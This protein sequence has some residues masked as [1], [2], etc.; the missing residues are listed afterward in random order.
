I[1]DI[2]GRPGRRT[3]K[4]VIEELIFKYNVDFI[5]A[6]GEN[7]AG[8][9]G[10]TKNVAE[11]LFDYKIDCL[12]MGNHTWDNKEIFDFIEEE[13]RIVR[14]ANYPPETP[15]RG[16][17]ILDKNDIKIGIINLLGRVFLPP[18]NCPFQEV[19]TILKK[20]KDE[21]DIIIVDF[22]A[23]ATSEKMAMGWFLDGKVSAVLG[24]HTHVQT[25]DE[26]ILPRGT[27]YI[28]DVG[29][30]GPVNSVLGVRHELVVNKFITQLPT[31]F[32]VASGDT[33]FNGAIIETNIKDGKANR[34]IR[35]NF[36]IDN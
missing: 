9:A 17:I 27:G 34:I 18:L 20:I 8:G 4:N 11:E 35:I 30:T 1:G 28:T 14:P 32:K 36:Q 23:E 13:T 25:A 24:T 33:M 15:G 5:I 22:H 16:Y 21:A 2:V 6:N 12:T 31:R 19:K 7:S 3:V 29:M 10:I 26:R